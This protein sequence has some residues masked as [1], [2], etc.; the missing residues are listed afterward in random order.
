MNE[1]LFPR[2]DLGVAVQL[3]VVLVL[4]G[5]ILWRTWHRSE[6]RLVTVGAA[7]LTLALIGLR[8]AH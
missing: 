2:T 4:S 1:L 6:F 8:A 5:V 7:L 3:A